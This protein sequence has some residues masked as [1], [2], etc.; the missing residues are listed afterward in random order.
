MEPM[1]ARA[2]LWR[3]LGPDDRNKVA[4][5]ERS[6]TKRR[7]LQGFEIC[8]LC[9][10]NPEPVSEAELM[11]M[12]RVAKVYSQELWKKRCIE[13]KAE[14][15]HLNDKEIGQMVD[16]KIE[17]EDLFE[18]Q[19]YATANYREPMKQRRETHVAMYG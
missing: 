6:L 17:P 9:A 19:N 1:I 18:W 16:G 15:Q 2:F 3:M 13:L 7:Y 4:D 5:L 12:A 14:N 10:L 8:R 11:E